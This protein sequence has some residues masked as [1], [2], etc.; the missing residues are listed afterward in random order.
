[1]DPT[2]SIRG[3]S[4]VKDA[5]EKYD[6]DLT[7]LLGRKPEK[8]RGLER[9][10]PHIFER[11]RA[12]SDLPERLEHAVETWKECQPSPSEAANPVE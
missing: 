9:P 3:A 2:Y 6:I 1:M 4:S 11:F 8:A 12:H 10:E 7:R 5:A